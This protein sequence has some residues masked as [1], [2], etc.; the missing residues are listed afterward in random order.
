TREVTIN[1]ISLSDDNIIYTSTFNLTA[2][3]S[4]ISPVQ[5]TRQ[6]AIARCGG[7]ENLPRLKDLTSATALGQPGI[8]AIGNLHGEWGNITRI[9]N[10]SIFNVWTN[11]IFPPVYYYIV[12]VSVGIP[13]MQS[14]NAHINTICRTIL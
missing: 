14:E 12:N 13:N 4:T 5:D 3:F 11:E 8:R 6:Q 1:F 10:T 2:W 7:A 9:L